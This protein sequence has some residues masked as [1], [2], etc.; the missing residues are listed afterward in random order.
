MDQKSRLHD[1]P[2]GH[3]MPRGASKLHRCKPLHTVGDAHVDD[4]AGRLAEDGTG[5]S[6]GRTL[7]VLISRHEFGRL[8]CRCSYSTFLTGIPAFAKAESVSELGPGG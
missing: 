1:R 4:A 5:S 6:L 7:Y 3:G 8:R 2:S